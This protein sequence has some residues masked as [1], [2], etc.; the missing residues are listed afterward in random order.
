MVSFDGT[1]PKFA[2]LFD[3]DPTT[4]RSIEVFYADRALET[5]GKSGAGWFWHARPLGRD[6]SLANRQPFFSTLPA[7]R[8]RP[9]K[10]CLS[11]KKGTRAIYEAYLVYML[12]L[13]A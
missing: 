7:N 1:N 5:F 3:V 10:S 4:G 13:L 9:T 11:I 2:P 6:F 8:D 12:K